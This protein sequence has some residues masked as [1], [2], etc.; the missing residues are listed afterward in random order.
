MDEDIREALDRYAR[1]LFA[2]EDE[3]LARIQPASAEQGMPQ[4]SIKADEGRMLQFLLKAVGARRVIE[5]GTLAGYSGTW[6]ARALPPDGRLISLDNTPQHAEFARQT[7]ASAGLS[8]RVEVRLGNAH[9]LLGKLAT[10]GPFDAIFIDANKD[11]YPA[12]LDWAVAHI[13]PG[14]L[15]MARS[16]ERRVGKEC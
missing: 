6:I 2:P 9:D 1:A 3:V 10:E 16:E 14:G 15:I 13:R 8:D 5:I 12:Y 7:F 11:D 4:I